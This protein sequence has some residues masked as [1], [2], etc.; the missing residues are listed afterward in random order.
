VSLGTD[1]RLDLIAQ[2]AA[3]SRLRIVTSWKAKN[4]I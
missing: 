4:E 1:L 2:W 3:L